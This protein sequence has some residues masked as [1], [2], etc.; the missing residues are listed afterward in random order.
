[1]AR[2]AERELAEFGYEVL[3]PI[4]AGAF[5]TVLRARHTGSGREVAVKTFD[6]AKC[7]GRETERDREL[8]VLRNLS[9]PGHAHIAHMIGEYHG[10]YA[11]H[12][13]LFYCSGGS[14]MRHL[15]KLK[16]KQQGLAE[17][18]AALL[19][20]QIGS[21]LR[22][23]HAMGVAHRDVKPANCLLDDAGSWRLCDFGFAIECADRKIRHVVGSPA[24]M[25]PE[26]AFGNPYI[27]RHV[28]M[29][30]FG[31]MMYE[32]LHLRPA[33]I[34]PTPEHLKLRIK[35][36][37]AAPFAK[38]LTAAAKA[39]IVALIVGQPENRWSANDVLQSEWVMQWCCPRGEDTAAERAVA[40]RA[41]N[42]E[43]Y[44]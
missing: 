6:A 38:Q 32:S 39:L 28:D 44:E 26:L 33:F 30:A 12:A 1:V 29:W 10:P 36:G 18:D 21:A 19:A 13:V 22:H 42:V 43:P 11:T 24:Y 20:A 41:R 37:F 31:C 40:G 9:D 3:G 2:S 34:A 25:A 14:L 7:Q 23:L 4:A 15:T 17:G 5:S 35:N 8:A 27:G 16:V